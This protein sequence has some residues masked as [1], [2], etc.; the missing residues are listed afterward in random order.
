[1]TVVLRVG[2]GVEG[3][4]E[5]PPELA[6]WARVSTALGSLEGEMRTI[7][8]HRAEQ[9]AAQYAEKLQVEIAVIDEADQVHLEP[10]PWGTGLAVTGFAVAVVLVALLA[11]SEGLSALNPVAAVAANILVVGGLAPTIWQCRAVPVWR[12]LALGALLGIAL[13]WTA[14]LVSAL[15]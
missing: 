12:W 9:L 2:G 5:L 3:L 8:R 4:A 11:L 15:F 1:M 13:A 7:V 10:T 14:L 6:E